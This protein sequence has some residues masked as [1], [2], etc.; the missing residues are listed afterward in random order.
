MRLGVLDRLQLPTLLITDLDPL[1]P[2]LESAIGRKR[3]WKRAVVK[4]G[5]TQRSANATLNLLFRTDGGKPTVDQLLDLAAI[6][7]RRHPPQRPYLHAAYQRRGIGSGECPTSLEDAVILTDGAWFSRQNADDGPLADVKAL[8]ADETPEPLATR[9]HG[10]MADNSF[11][12]GEF[13]AEL[14]MRSIAGDTPPCPDYI[15]DGLAGLTIALT[16]PGRAAPPA[17]SAEPE[18]ATEGV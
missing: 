11:S 18:P 17:P 15:T 9:L 6:P 8:L 16:A 10:L 4:Y 7:G 3:R 5:E 13:A 1:D 12:K 2:P 14:F